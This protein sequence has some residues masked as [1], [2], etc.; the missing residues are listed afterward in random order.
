MRGLTRGRWPVALF[1]GLLAATCSLL[2]TAPPVRSR[3][4]R[5]NLSCHLAAA[6]L[7]YP[8]VWFECLTV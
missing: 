1:M 2:A 8:P 6:C 7:V 5:A 3:S 4:I